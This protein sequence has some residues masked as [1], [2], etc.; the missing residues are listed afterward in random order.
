MLHEKHLCFTKRRHRTSDRLPKF[1][2]QTKEKMKYRA[3]CTWCTP[4]L[5]N[6]EKYVNSNY[7]RDKY[8]TYIEVDTI[9]EVNL[10]EQL[11]G[12]QEATFKIYNELLK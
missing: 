10:I 5:F 4:L 9:E 7:P 8:E 11:N 12:H 2:P 6:C 1:Y 3:K